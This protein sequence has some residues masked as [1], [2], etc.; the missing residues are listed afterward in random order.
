MN[1]IR[2]DSDLA[3]KLRRLGG[4]AGRSL[5]NIA[6]LLLRRQLRMKATPPA[7]AVSGSI[8]KG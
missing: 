3:E 6:N 5:T 2:L 8:R 1:Q 4:A 7:K